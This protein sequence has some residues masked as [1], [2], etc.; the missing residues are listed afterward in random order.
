MKLREPGARKGL[1]L[2]RMYQLWLCGRL[3]VK[4]RWNGAPFGQLHRRI[5]A[6][7]LVAIMLCQQAK[8]GMQAFGHSLTEDF[9]ALFRMN[10]VFLVTSTRPFATNVWP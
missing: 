2:P 9:F 3:R 10:D 4:S 5:H 6:S 7:Q 1:V 8:T